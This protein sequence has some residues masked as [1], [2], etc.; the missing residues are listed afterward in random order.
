MTWS[1]EPR[2]QSRYLT[3][4]V[5]LNGHTAT[6]RLETSP[7][8]AERYCSVCGS[9]TISACPA[10]HAG[11]RGDYVVPGVPVI[12]PYHPPHHCHNCGE[13]FPW[14]TSRIAAAKE[15]A[16]EL[17]IS[18]SDREILKS[19]IVDLSTDNPKTE[20]AAGRYKRIVSSVGKSAGN[21]LKSILVD[22]ITE[23][24]KKMLF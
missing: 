8:A 12:M 2:E 18:D 10:C 4:Q 6:D 13:Q 22:V 21:A 5:C 9:P 16:D 11:I 3:A 24:A 19:A 23:S 15:M 1:D 14:T 20:L 17:D 7:E